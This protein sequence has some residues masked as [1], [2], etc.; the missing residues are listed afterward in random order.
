MT[1]ECSETTG[2]GSRY[3]SV[4]TGS[5]IALLAFFSIYTYI[6][7]PPDAKAGETATKAVPIDLVSITVPEAF[8]LESAS[9]I[10]PSSSPIIR[11]VDSTS[12]LCLPGGLCF[13]TST[14]SFVREKEG[15]HK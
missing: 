14:F 10:L 13:P 6:T 11:C 8:Y 1:S 15:R 3:R 9:I 4:G 5:M 12:F 2:C 7:E